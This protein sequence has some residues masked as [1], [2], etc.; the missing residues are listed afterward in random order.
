M[1][2]TQRGALA[3]LS[4]PA[5]SGKWRLGREFVMRARAGPRP[6]VYLYAR[7]TEVVDSRPAGALLVLLNRWLQLPPER[8]AG[9]RGRLRLEALVAPDTAAEL[10]AALDPEAEAIS[11]GAL[12]ARSPNG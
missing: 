7:W 1:L 2:R 3:Y 5:G 6:P 9:E 8:P 12:D 11:T 10:L 4:G